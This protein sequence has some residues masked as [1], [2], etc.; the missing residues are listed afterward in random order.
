MSNKVTD[1]TA[2]MQ[3][4][5]KHV[6]SQRGSYNRVLCKSEDLPMVQ[7]QGSVTRITVMTLK[8]SDR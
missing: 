6:V 2:Q 3:T 4:A 1:Q 5:L 8:F 7:C